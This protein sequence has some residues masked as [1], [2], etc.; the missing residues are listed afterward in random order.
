MAQKDVWVI[1][2]QSNAEGIA[3]KTTLPASLRGPQA[4]R[5][6]WNHDNNAV[7]VL[8]VDGVGANLPNNTTAHVAGW[9]GPELSLAESALAESSEVYIFKY[10]IL[11]SSLGPNVLPYWA[12]TGGSLINT[13]ATRWNSFVAAMAL[14]GHTVRVKRVVWF[15]GETDAQLPGLD[16]AYYGMFRDLI[17]VVRETVGSPA[18]PWITCLIH[19]NLYPGNTA[20]YIRAASTVRASQMRAGWAD[21]NYRIVDSNSFSRSVDFIHL[22]TEGVVACGQ[23]IYAAHLLTYNNSMALEEYNLREIRERLAEEGGID[24]TIPENMVTID[25]RINDANA[26]IHNRRR[27]W[28]FT[29]REVSIDIGELSTNKSDARYGAG[30]FS[31][32]QRNVILCSY[33]ISSIAEREIVNFDGDGLDGLVVTTS[34]LL[35]STINT[36]QAFRGDPQICNITAIT[37]GNPTIVTVNLATDS[38]GTAVIPT[39]VPTFGVRIEGASVTAPPP[40]LSG[41]YQATRISSNSFSIPVSTVAETIATLGTAQ[42]AREFRIAQGYFQSPE[43]YVSSISLHL[44]TDTEENTV[45]YRR[46]EAFERELRDSRVASTLK[47]IYTVI[48]DPIGTT[49][50]KFIAVFPFFTGRNVLQAKYYGNVK[51]LVADEDVSD[52]PIEHRIVLYYAAK[53]F[54]AQWQKDATM[55]PIYRDNALTEL[56][57][58]SQE[59]QMSDDTTESVDDTDAGVGMPRPPAGFPEFFEP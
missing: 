18:A 39:N 26:W 17:R 57:R 19:N 7:E 55:I 36:K 56:E 6:I 15:Q 10:A 23:A 31:R 35:G 29:E 58:M 13:F 3:D 45:L 46:P 8:N 34:T 16:E 14:L 52:I 20:T 11:G 2:G 37:P 28:P 49:K 22:D 21:K 59:Y 32:H 24:I 53:W 33:N 5:F 38:G 43:D 40:T 48:P 9:C 42:I 41:S 47:R 51:K 1:L 25:R 27:S 12:P 30:V 50:K 4:N 54:V 44:D